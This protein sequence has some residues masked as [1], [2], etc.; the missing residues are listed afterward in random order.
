MQKQPND[1][2][3]KKDISRLRALLMRRLTVSQLLLMIMIF[4]VGILTAWTGQMAGHHM[5][6]NGAVETSATLDE[7]QLPR[8]L[9][10]LLVERQDG[11]LVNLWDLMPNNRNVL[12]VYAPWCP[13][14]QKELPKLNESLAETVNLV[15]L[16][17]QNENT[18]QVK[19]QLMNLG[20]SGIN[21]YRDVTGQILQQGK[22]T[23][24]PTTFLLRDFGRITD[25]LVGYSDYK[26]RRLIKRAQDTSSYENENK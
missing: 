21:Y 13:G 6:P 17:D 19:E 12:T 4:I 11:L 26:M 20:L 5:S 8:Q 25:R 15:V 1:N 10:N 24:L 22:V 14:C 18:E 2:P 3:I 7:L 9:P 16:I 23:K